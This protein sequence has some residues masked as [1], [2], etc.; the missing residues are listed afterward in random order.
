MPKDQ[1]QSEEDGEVGVQDDDPLYCAVCGN[2]ATRERWRMAK[3]GSH[4]HTFFNPI[5]L[6]FLVLCFKEAPGCTT[7][8]DATEEHTWF[9]GFSWRYALCR[10]CGEHLGWLY[11][12]RD[13]L[14][15]FFG[16]IGPRL[17]TKPK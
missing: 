9:P 14:T 16:L 12:S 4:E 1:L 7:A 13:G 15:A 11:E 5:G 3:D 6:T 8:G 2:L 10:G 17:T